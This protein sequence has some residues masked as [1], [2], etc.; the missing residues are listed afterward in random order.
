MATLYSIL[1][2]FASEWQRDLFFHNTPLFSNLTSKR[3][4]FGTI[5]KYLVQYEGNEYPA[6]LHYHS[7][8]PQS[9]IR[10]RQPQNV[11]GKKGHAQTNELYP[12][13]E[14]FA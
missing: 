13:Q 8:N 3:E 11:C 1:L 2:P 5:R 12:S 7:R 14:Q 10:N 6:C 9:P 4:V